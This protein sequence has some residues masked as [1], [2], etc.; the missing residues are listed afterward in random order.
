MTN[1]TRAC[2]PT[3]IRESPRQSSGRK[4][5]EHGLRDGVLEVAR[6]SDAALLVADRWGFGH[7]GAVIAIHVD[8][9]GIDATGDAQRSLDVARPHGAGETELDTV[10]EGER[11]VLVVEAHHR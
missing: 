3:P 10:R 8:L 9:P 2:E 1:L 6:L 11:V 7:R 4:T 5:N